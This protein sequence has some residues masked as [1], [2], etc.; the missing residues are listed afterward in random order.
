[1]NVEILQISEQLKDAYQGD[2]WFGRSVKALLA[3]VS[4]DIAFEKLN[5]QHSIVELLWHMIIWREF[6]IS[7]L[8]K[9]GSQALGYY[10]ENDWRE[11]NHTDTSLWEKGLKRL[12]ETQAELIAVIEKQTDDL[13]EKTVAERKYNFRNLLHGVIQHDIYHL[14]QIAYIVKG[15]RSK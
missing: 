10:E 6:T 3:D 12:D 5:D 1:M 9:D 14:G 15:L 13:L 7:R 2:P 4:E 11:L 8:Q